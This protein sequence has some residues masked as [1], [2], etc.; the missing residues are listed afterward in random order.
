MYKVRKIRFINHPVLKNMEL[1]FTGRN[2]EDIRR[3][4]RSN[5]PDHGEMKKGIATAVLYSRSS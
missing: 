3:S 5:K 2:G 1:D 4:E